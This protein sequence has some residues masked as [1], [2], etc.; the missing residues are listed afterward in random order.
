[1]PLVEAFEARLAPGA[2]MLVLVG[3]S[4]ALDALV[5]AVGADTSA[6]HRQALTSE[7]A[8][9]LSKASEA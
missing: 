2:S 4:P 6:V 3:E 1:M 7:Q 5:A 8:A 9:E